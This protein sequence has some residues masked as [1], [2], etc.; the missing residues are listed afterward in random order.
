MESSWSGKTWRKTKRVWKGD[1]GD[2]Y[3]Y[4]DDDFVDND[5]IN[6]DLWK[7]AGLGKH[8]GKQR[9][10]ENGFVHDD[11]KCDD[12]DKDNEWGKQWTVTH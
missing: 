1:N 12:V 8:E 3:E 4:N 6:A 10:F 2:D 5:D 7:A 9:G 11:E